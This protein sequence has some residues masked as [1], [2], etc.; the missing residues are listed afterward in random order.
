M[1]AACRAGS[2]LTNATEIFQEGLRISREAGIY[3]DTLVAFLRQNVRIPDTVMGDLKPRSPP[4]RSAPAAS[5]N[6]PNAS[7]TTS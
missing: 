1:S 6:W 4:A 7:A 3:N 5:P 2:V